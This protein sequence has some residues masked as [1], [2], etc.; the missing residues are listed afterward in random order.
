MVKKQE[1]KVVQVPQT[2]SQKYLAAQQMLS[3]THR[4]GGLVTLGKALF[5]AFV[6]FTFLA[7]IIFTVI[8]LIRTCVEY[9]NM[10]VWIP[11]NNWIV[12]EPVTGPATMFLFYASGAM[13]VLYVLRDYFQ[14]GYFWAMSQF[15]TIRYRLNKQNTVS[16]EKKKPNESVQLQRNSSQGN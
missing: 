8:P 9:L 1:V 14:I 12:Q 5:F 2:Y 11:L 16:A 15:E 6:V 13:L 10:A 7:G 4:P 3:K